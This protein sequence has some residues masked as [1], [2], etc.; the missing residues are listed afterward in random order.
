MK[1]ILITLSILIGIMLMNVEAY[2]FYWT[3]NSCINSDPSFC[4]E[5]LKS[6]IFNHYVNT[7]E[8]E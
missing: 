4:I 1:K 7:H 6:M 3:G 2:A 5:K 8:G